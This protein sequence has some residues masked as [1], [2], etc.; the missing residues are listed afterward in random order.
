MLSSNG[1]IA[2]LVTAVCLTQLSGCGITGRRYS[3]SYDGPPKTDIDVSKLR[4]AIPKEEPLHP[5]GT[6]SYSLGGRH[7]RVLK[8]P[9]GYV[10]RGY[11]S[12][13]GS[14]F[15]GGETST[16]ERF[17]LYAMTAASPE[18][19]L[20]SYAEVTNLH[21][22]KKI[23]V[24]INDRGPFHGNRILD[25]SYAAAKKLGFADHGVA[26]VKVVGID[27][28]T[29]GRKSFA[30]DS[31]SN[32]KVD[33]SEVKTKQ[34]NQ[35]SVFLQLGVFT[36]LGHAKQLSHKIYSVLNKQAEI[37]RKSNFY[38]VQIGPLASKQRDR[39]KSLL[40]QNGFEYV[41]VVDG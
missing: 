38:R 12:W 9:K 36:E 17:N 18:L 16:Q 32:P 39:F 24:R 23:V 33:V 27:P 20:P 35:P 1:L 6:R 26:P 22:G 7:Y 28:K 11:A 31:H 37:K 3:T 13:Y 34:S 4:D 14:K 10:K 8:S 5:Y 19:P 30:V 41:T 15:H 25:L 2:V 29:W 40:E 21:N